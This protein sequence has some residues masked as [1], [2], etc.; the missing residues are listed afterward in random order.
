VKLPRPMVILFGAGATRAAFSGGM[1]PPPLD[2]DFFD[3]AGQ[4]TGRGTR[5]LAQQVA[6]DVFELYGRVTGIGLE[7]YYRDIET[8]LELSKF[9]KSKNRP[10]DWLVRTKN[11]QELVRR[12]LVHTTCDLDEGSAKPRCSGIHQAL[13][14]RVKA[15]DTLI[16]FNYDTVIEESMSESATLWTPRGGYA[17]DASGITHDWAKKWFEKRGIDKAE[18]AQVQLLKLHGSLNWV[19]YKTS[20]VRLKPRPYV[21]R[22]KKGKAVFDKAAILPPGWHKRV[23]KN[24]YNALWQKA[25]TELEKCA[26]LVIVGYSLPETD[27]IARALFLEASRLRETKGSFLKE[28]HVADISESAKNRIVDLFVPALGPHGLVFR[29]SGAEQLANA[30]SPKVVS[31]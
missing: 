24:P 8:R 1:P 3:I 30:W 2:T 14:A 6:R 10:K 12:V 31:T 11:L 27:L 17:V 22:A 23:D 18:E 25:R 4:L 16:T 28:L 7:Q 26:T 13:L 29:Y 20:K 21:V 5:R 15:G 9:A 19:L